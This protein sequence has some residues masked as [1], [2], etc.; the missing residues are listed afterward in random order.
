MKG[1]RAGLDWSR[2]LN[3]ISQPELEYGD[4]LTYCRQFEFR[5]APIEDGHLLLRIQHWYL[6]PAVPYPYIPSHAKIT[7]CPHKQNFGFKWEVV[8]GLYS[9]D[10]RGAIDERPAQNDNLERNKYLCPNCFT[11]YRVDSKRISDST[12]AICVTVLMT[13]KGGLQTSLPGS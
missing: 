8:S 2:Y 3:D 4:R 12:W 1:H 7:I 10:G 6:L 5:I 11:E 9:L 13:H